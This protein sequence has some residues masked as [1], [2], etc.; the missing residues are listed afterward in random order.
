MDR[1][2]SQVDAR[3][4]ELSK[5]KGFIAGRHASEASQLELIRELQRENRDAR[6]ENE[7]LRK[8]AALK[9]ARVDLQRSPL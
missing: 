6:A 1:L 5:V 8:I 2:S 7:S 9:I 3:D 4:Q